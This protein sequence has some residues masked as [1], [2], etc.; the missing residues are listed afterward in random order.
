MFH[1]DA[2]RVRIGY[3]ITWSINDMI[4]RKTT[5]A[6]TR[7]AAMRLMTKSFWEHAGR[8]GLAVVGR[9]SVRGEIQ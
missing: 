6:L 4:G 3:N 5:W 1:A 8:G 7:R 2:K 9:Y